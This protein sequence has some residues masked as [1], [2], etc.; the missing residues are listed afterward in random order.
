MLA[1]YRQDLDD[2]R[3]LNKCLHNTLMDHKK[4][5]DLQQDAVQLLLS[6][7]P[8]FLQPAPEHCGEDIEENPWAGVQ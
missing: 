5:I 4:S 8:A 1:G 6:N 2:H 3:A 7:H